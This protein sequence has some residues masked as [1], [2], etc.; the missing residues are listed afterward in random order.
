LEAAAAIMEKAHSNSLRRSAT[1]LIE[2]LVDIM[3]ELCHITAW[4]SVG[5]RRT[6]ADSG[7][8]VERQLP[9]DLFRRT[10]G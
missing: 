10:T 1:I 9:A 7:Q 5:Q 3:P 8:I 4:N 6:A 2:Q